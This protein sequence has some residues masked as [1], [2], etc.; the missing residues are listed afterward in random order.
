MRQCLC[1]ILIFIIFRIKYDF[2]Q[3]L[4]LGQHQPCFIREEVCFPCFVIWFKFQINMGG[5]SWVKIHHTCVGHPHQKWYQGEQRLE[6]RIEG[7]T[8]GCSL[9]HLFCDSW[10]LVSK[11]EV[12]QICDDILLLQHELS[13]CHAWCGYVSYHFEE[14]LEL[15]PALQTFFIMQNEHLLSHKGIQNSVHIL[16]S[17][18][19]LLR[20]RAT[21]CIELEQSYKCLRSK[22]SNLILWIAIRTIEQNLEQM[23]AGIIQQILLSMLANNWCFVI[24]YTILRVREGHDTHQRVGDRRE[25]GILIVIG[26][27]VVAY[28]AA[29]VKR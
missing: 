28:F 24:L 8:H 22:F 21:I 20:F 26:Q 6:R 23:L 16:D 10:A 13:S 25:L 9:F 17:I 3:K 2:I 14:E 15:G 12:D 5:K 11:N 19:F 29:D 18:A 7:T 27:H 1:K 4:G